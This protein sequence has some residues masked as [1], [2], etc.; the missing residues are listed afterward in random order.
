MEITNLF[1]SLQI[2]CAQTQKIVPLKISQIANPTL[3]KN[4]LQINQALPVII[5]SVE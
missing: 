2:K 4:F 5:V 1:H 3:L